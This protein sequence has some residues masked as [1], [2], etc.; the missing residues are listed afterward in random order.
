MEPISTAALA[1]LILA[2]RSGAE[3]LGR[4]AG[5][6]TWT[7]LNKLKALVLRTFSGNDKASLALAVAE[8]HPENDQAVARL[9]DSIEECAAADSVFADELQQLIDDA[10]KRPEYGQGSTLFSNYGYAGK[11]NIFT[12]TVRVEHGGFNIN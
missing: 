11:V 1:A 10:R 3:E 7:G 6:S 5:H 8:Q 12:G 2:S 9:R 4:E